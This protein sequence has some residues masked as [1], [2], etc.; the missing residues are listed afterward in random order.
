[1]PILSFLV[2]FIICFAVLARIKILGSKFLELLVSFIIAII[3]VS[4][5]GPRNYILAIIPWFA[6]LIVGLFLVMVLTGF[7]GKDLIFMNKGIGIAFVVLLLIAFVVSIFFVFS[8]YLGPYLPFSSGAG[9]SSGGLAF[10]NWLY[11]P[12]VA[13]AILLLAI[14]FVVSWFLVKG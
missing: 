3:F 8:S 6:I 4:A 2:V 10:A 9:G 5:V 11:S 14:S 12:R 13:G 7:V 1:M